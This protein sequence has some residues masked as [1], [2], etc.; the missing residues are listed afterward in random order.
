[1][2]AYVLGCCCLLALTKLKGTQKSETIKLF[3]PPIDLIIFQT[4]LLTF[5]AL[6]TVGSFLPAAVGLT[7][8]FAFFIAS[9]GSLSTTRCACRRRRRHGGDDYGGGDDDDNNLSDFSDN[10]SDG[11]CGA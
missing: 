8:A 11:Q 7:G 1:M 4:L 2:V 9:N 3:K 10:N 6:Y 5:F